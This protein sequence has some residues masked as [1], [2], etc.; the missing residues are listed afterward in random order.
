M[1]DNIEN[2]GADGCANGNGNENG[3]DENARCYMDR[4]VGVRGVQV[5]WLGPGMA[6][7]L[8]LLRD[9][10][11]SFPVLHYLKPEHPSTQNPKP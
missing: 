9:W 8:K 1:Y 2:D 6:I 7:F 5:L 10:I 4:L 3:I 11:L